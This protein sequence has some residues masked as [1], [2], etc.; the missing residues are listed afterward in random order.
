M[1]G[2]LR[3]LLSC[4]AL[5]VATGIWCSNSY[6]YKV[7]KTSGGTEIKWSS[8]STTYYINPSGGPSG[9]LSA[10]QAAMQAWTDVSSSAFGFVYGGTTSSTSYGANDGTNIVCFGSL[11]AGILAQNSFWF[12]GDSHPNPL[13][14][15][16]LLDSDIKFNTD[17]TYATNGSGGAYD[18]Q[19]I[20]THELGHSLSL[21]DL[22]SASDSEKT[23]YGYGTLGDIEKRTLDQD[24]IDGISHL[25]PSGATTT[26]TSSTTSTT[27]S[28]TSTSSSTTTSV[29]GPPNLRYWQAPNG[30]FS[31]TPQSNLSWGDSVTAYYGVGNYGNGDI[32]SGTRYR[33]R[34]YISSNSYISTADYYWQGYYSDSGLPSGYGVYGN[35][36]K[37]LP[38]LPPSGFSSTG[39]IYIGMIV[40]PLDE[41]TESNENDNRNQGVSKDYGSLGISGGVVTTTT[42]TSTSTSSSSTS[43]SSTSSSS[44]TSTTLTTST[45]TTSQTTST[46][47][48]STSTTTTSIP[49][50]PTMATG[51]GSG[52]AGGNI[53]LPI[54]LT[55][56]TGVS[57]AAVS[58]DI[59]YDATIFKTPSAVIGPAGE[60]AGKTVAMG[61][62]SAG[63]FRVSVLSTSNNTVI[64]DG[65][66]A[67]LTLGIQTN[68]PTGTTTLTTT[69]SGSDPSG[70]DVTVIGS[71]GTVNII[72]GIAG[73]CDGDGN[74]SIA[75]LQ[76]AI[77]MFLGLNTIESCVD[78]NENGR[79]SIAEIQ[80]VINNHLGLTGSGLTSVG[81]DLMGFRGNASHNSNTAGSST[82]PSLEI[83][84]VSGEPGEAVTVPMTLTNASGY[85][86]S[87][88]SSDIVYDT[89]RLENPIVEIGPAGTAASKTVTSSEPSS[90]TFR[91]GVLSIANND[92]VGDGVVAYLIFTIKEA[93][94]RTTLSNSPEGSDPAG[95][96]VT[97]DG[98]NG[99]VT[100]ASIIYVDPSA[101]C[102]GND[103]CFSR[104]QNGIDSATTYSVIKL[105]EGTYNE[106]IT[107]D[108]PNGLILQGG[109]DSTFTTQSSNT[110]I[111]SLTISGGAGTV[112]IENVV[113][114]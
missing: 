90:G 24:D 9:S 60:A 12:Y 33:F 88:I 54:T 7:S 99:S 74:V 81:N 32:P 107:I 108:Q 64:G 28:T 63:I 57:V 38:S 66:V 41:I 71:H 52:E 13:L 98:R 3:V 75:E 17:Y 43:S 101:Q 48:T 68:T 44:T 93:W 22:Y 102:G 35:F 113:L 50:A 114:E 73:D 85:N 25:Y 30:S 82:A 20:G 42:S 31:L 11:G 21:A 4:L 89:S 58:V 14:V 6:A 55:N 100:A 40:D 27:S 5:F 79:V 70:G 92:A 106:D 18:V 65:V 26:T 95:N 15:G 86:I 8:T 83:G 105:N 16:K 97:V 39:T 78:V 77:N 61:D 45:T 96:D 94:G 84:H 69:A 47:T 59:E 53:T 2:S 103:S 51:S 91:V 72:S 104:I 37:A 19:N 10:I 49:V 110:V 111:K 76:S 1:A 87:A 34:F 56:K 23:M 109:W 80:K 67:Y 36:T 46:T 29:S 112:E 62:I